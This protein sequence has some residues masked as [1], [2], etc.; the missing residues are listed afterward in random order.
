MTPPERIAK[1]L[2]PHL[3]ETT[4]DV[5]ARHLC[6]KHDI[7]DGPIDANKAQQLQETLRRGLVAFVGNDLARELSAQCCA[8]LG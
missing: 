5:V 2:G 8:G 1:I 4:A 3:G 7:G 6:A